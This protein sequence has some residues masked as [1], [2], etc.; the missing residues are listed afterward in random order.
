MPEIKDYVVVGSSFGGA[1][2]ALRLAEAGAQVV[3]L[4][5]GK[6]RTR[7]DFRQT[8]SVRHLAS[9]YRTLT[10]DAYE[11][12]LR[13]GN[14]LGGGSVLFSGAMLRPPREAFDYADRTGYRLW[15]AAV[16]RAALEPHLARVETEMEISQARWDEIPMPGAV[17]AMLFDSM[18]LTCD[19]IP[20]NYVDCL[21]CGFCEAG[22]R[23]DRKRS[24]L[25]NY[26]PRAEAHGAELWT[27]CDAVS[28][29]PHASG[30]A[31][32]YLD[33]D[34]RERVL[35]GRRVLLAGNA[36]ETAALLLRSRDQLPSL[37]EQTGRNFH[38]NGDFAWY[39]ELPPGRFPTFRSYKGRNNAAM[40]SYAF[41]GSDRV[42]I[43]TGS[44]PPG[45]FAG[46]EVHRDEEGPLGRPWGLEHKHWAR[47]VYRD[48][49]L[50]SALA[51]GLCDGE[52]VVSVNAGGRPRV[53]IPVTPSLQAY[54][55]RVLAIARRIADA[56]GAR[57]I[58]S[59]KTGYERGGAH[60][61]ATCRMGDDPARSVT[62]AWGQVHGLPDLICTDSSIIPGSTGVNP[63][64]TIAANAERIA[65]HLVENG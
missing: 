59:T 45:I 30:Y 5:R 7:K 1:I 51:I 12:T 49:R 33:R 9:L 43:H 55:D 39:W 54:H 19:R 53:S 6:R 57:V 41:W 26:I 17:F 13:Y 27:E 11:I 35:V 20:F 63:A 48:G 62:D 37:P 14:L 31:V 3:V 64:L 18:G 47:E 38:T 4:E 46:T 50:S 60:L 44:L 24:L 42:T 36:I 22:C 34:G 23:F 16:D 58:L 2:P 29:A 40:M 25:L 28:V 8:W 32:R 56:N 61:L 10:H 15:P 65:A 21:Q 52:G